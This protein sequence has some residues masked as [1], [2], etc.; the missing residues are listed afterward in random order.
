MPYTVPT[1]F[2]NYRSQIVDLDA[3]QVKTARKSRDYLKEQLKS[4]AKSVPNFPQTQGETIDFGSFSRKTK[5]RE[6]D[7][8]DFLFLVSAGTGSKALQIEFNRYNVTIPDKTCPTW[9]Y[10]N[11]DDL[12]LNSRKILTKIRNS[13]DG[14]HNY[15]KAEIK[16]TGEAVVL[17]LKSYPWRFDIV[18]AVPVSDGNGGRSY[19]LIP[20]G[21]GTW[22]RTDPRRDKTNITTANTYHNG[23][24][25]PVIRIIKYWNAKYYDVPKISSYFLETLLING[26]SIYQPL[27]SVRG[28][29]KVAFD[30]LHSG[31]LNFCPDPK[32]LEDN[33]DK[34]ETYE[35]KLKVYSTTSTMATWAMYAL[36]EESKGNYKEAIEWWRKVLP[37]FPK[38][39]G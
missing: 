20:D 13:L 21:Q 7:D 34:H 27:P 35:T 28:S 24:L 3:E 29:I 15:Q 10:T 6:L 38:Y 26:F 32:G 30:V 23:N 1:A 14:V 17:E 31:I 2:T 9:I 16:Y 19:Y 8:I 39:G 4:I 25:I 33:L 18:P 11:D 37:G 36:N 5:V 22:K 12:T